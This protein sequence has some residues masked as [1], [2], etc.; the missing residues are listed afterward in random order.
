MDFFDLRAVSAI[1]NSEACARTVL[2]GHLC[3][4]TNAKHNWYKCRE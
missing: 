3:R 2:S 1:I 4:S